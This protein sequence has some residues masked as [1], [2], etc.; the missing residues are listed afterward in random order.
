[1]EWTAGAQSATDDL[2]IVKNGAET[3]ITKLRADAD[4][5]AYALDQTVFT[6]TDGMVHF[7]TWLNHDGINDANIGRNQFIHLHVL[8]VASINGTGNGVFPGYPGDPG[9]PELPI[10][11]FED[12]PNNPDPLKPEDPIDGAPAQLKVKVT[13]NPWTYKENSVILAK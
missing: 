13:V 8:G 6:Y 10:D 12:D 11:P 9:N 1:V 7:I 2:Y 3:Y 4:A 5:I